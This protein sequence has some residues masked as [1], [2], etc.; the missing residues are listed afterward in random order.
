MNQVWLALAT[1]T[2]AGLLAA[3]VGFF[4]L[5]RQRRQERQREAT[6]QKS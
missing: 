2:V 4:I 5:H 6:T 3:A 1:P